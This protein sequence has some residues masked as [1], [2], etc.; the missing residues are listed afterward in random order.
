MCRY[1]K[2][3]NSGCKR[4]NDCDFLHDTLA[5]DDG[6][7]AQQDQEQE[8]TCVGCKSCFA[9]MRCIVQHVVSNQKVNFCLNCDDWVK[10][11]TKVL[12]SNWTLLDSRGNLRRD[13]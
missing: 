2:K 1:W 4:K 5:R 8:Y 6:N 12:D 3:I 11:K 10:D 7:S 13:V 9:D